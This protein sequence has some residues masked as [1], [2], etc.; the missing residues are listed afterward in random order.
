MPTAPTRNGI[1]LDRFNDA[2]R[3]SPAWQA[4][5]RNAGY[6]VAAGPQ[7]IRLSDAQRRQLQGQLER[8]GFR[9]P[10]GMQIDPAGNVN[11]D[12]GVS[13][14]VRNPWIMV[15]VIAGATLATMGAAGFGPLAGLLSSGGSAAGA[16]GGAAAGVL[17]SGTIPGLHAAI[18][19]IIG[20]QG[21]SGG[22]GLGGAL[23]GGAIG[24]LHNALPP[25][26]GSQGV[27]RTVPPLGGMLPGG[28]GGSV[29]PPLDGG[30]VGGDGGDGFNIRDFFTDPTNLGAIIAALA[31]SGLIGNGGGGDSGMPDELRRIYDITEQRMRRVDP[32]HQAATNLAWGRLPISSRSGVAG[33]TGGP[34][35]PPRGPSDQP[36]PQAVPR[37]PDNPRAPLDPRGEDGGGPARVPPSL[38]PWERPV[39]QPSNMQQAVIAALAKRGGAY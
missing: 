9:F 24:G 31:G 13:A 10:S 15:P 12:Q 21:V 25:A 14:A 29:N 35:A 27:S 2:L 3:E 11:Q 4:F 39:E 5:M 30:G 8:A 18:P 20:S 19:G 34:L 32:L 23:A 37:W 7:R 26:I 38:D 1:P 17:P 28:R 22:I 16:A 36:P 6:D 33:P